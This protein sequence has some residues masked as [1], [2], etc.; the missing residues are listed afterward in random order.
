M[1]SLLQSKV[2]VMAL[3]ITGDQHILNFFLNELLLKLIV[4]LRRTRLSIANNLR[5][6][7]EVKF[8][9]VRTETFEDV[10]ALSLRMLTNERC[11]NMTITCLIRYEI[12]LF[13][14]DNFKQYAENWA[15]IIPRC[16]GN[17]L[18]YFLP[19]EGTNNIAWGAI[20]FDNLARYEVYRSKLKLDS[21]GKAN[22]A[23]AQQEHFI[24]R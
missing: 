5:W 17:L 4:F 14:R 6:F 15:C 10:F 18:G 20:A 12:D 2:R 11:Q 1:P 3:C 19:Y 21:D 22:F 23:F 24:L 8:G 13:Q 9:S 7:F 16:G